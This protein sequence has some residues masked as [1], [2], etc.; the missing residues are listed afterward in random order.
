MTNEELVA[1]LKSLGFVTET[2]LYRLH[3]STKPITTFVY[4]YESKVVYF[5]TSS[6][7]SFWKFKYRDNTFWYWIDFEWFEIED[8]IDLPTML[9][10][11]K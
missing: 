10:L 9:V 5:S 8:E 6:D 11:Y 2:H 3:V 1:E 4:L 7:S